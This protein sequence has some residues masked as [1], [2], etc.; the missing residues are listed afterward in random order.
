MEEL[1]KKIQN[2]INPRK[3]VVNTL[4]LD[5]DEITKFDNE[6]TIN[7][8]MLNIVDIAKMFLVPKLND[9]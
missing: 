4:L 1:H 6:N 5:T 2:S 8:K 3:P 7:S 9:Q